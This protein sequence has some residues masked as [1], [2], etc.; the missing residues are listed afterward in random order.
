MFTLN[1]SSQKSSLNSLGRSVALNSVEDLPVDTHG[2]WSGMRRA[3]WGLSVCV[4]HCARVTTD[5]K[6]KKHLKNTCNTILSKGPCLIFPCV[7]AH[8][9]S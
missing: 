5:F 4:P 2:K 7:E 6:R 8:L 9:L 1:L 3:R